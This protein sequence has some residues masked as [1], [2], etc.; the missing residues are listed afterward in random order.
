LIPFQIIS[1]TGIELELS[2]SIALPKEN[3]HQRQSDHGT[4]TTASTHLPCS[5]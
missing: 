4:S 5:Q 3:L 2:L 1:T